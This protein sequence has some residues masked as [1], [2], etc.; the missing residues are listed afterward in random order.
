M[1]DPRTI[2]NTTEAEN[3]AILDTEL[4]RKL[5]KKGE[6]VKRCEECGESFHPKRVW[7]NFCSSRCSGRFH[8]KKEE[9]R[10]ENLEKSRNA[11]EAE[12]ERLFRENQELKARIEQ[13]EKK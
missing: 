5:I 12:A 7:Q 8:M 3:Q 10:I 6:Y 4:L 1:K 2:F 13:L 11:W 9:L